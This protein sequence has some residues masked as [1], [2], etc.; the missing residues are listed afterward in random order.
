MADCYA[1][2]AT[3][4]EFIDIQTKL[5]PKYIKN[6]LK[7]VIIRNWQLE[8]TTSPKGREVFAICRTV[9]TKRLHGNFF[10]NQIITGH[11]ALA[12]YQERFFNKTNSCSC[13]PVIEDRTF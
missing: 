6:L 2:Q 10:I 8:W 3:K 12:S 1:K 13:G 5:T 9:S 7:Q 11:G 4:R